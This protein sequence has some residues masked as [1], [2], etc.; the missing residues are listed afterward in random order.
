[1]KIY[2]PKDRHGNQ[3]GFITPESF[4]YDENGKSLTDK[5]Y[6]INVDINETKE[7]I[8]NTIINLDGSTAESISDVKSIADSKA[9]INDSAVDTNTTWSSRKINEEDEKIKSEISSLSNTLTTADNELSNSISNVKSIADSKTSIDDSVTETGTTWSSDKINTEITNVVSD[10]TKLSNELNDLTDEVTLKAVIDDAS[11]NTSNTWSGEKIN[12]T[13]NT[14]STKITSVE[15]LANSKVAI[16]DSTTGTDTTWS[17]N[18]INTRISDATSSLDSK[19]KVI[20]GIVNSNTSIDDD[21]SSSSTTWSSNKINDAI[22]ESVSNAEE[23]LSGEITNVS[24]TMNQKIDST[25]TE[26]KSYTDTKIS[27]L[28][29]SAPETLSTLK[30]L[31]DALSE[32]GEVVEA[33]NDAIAEKAD[34]KEF[35]EHVNNSMIHVTDAERVKWNEASTHATSNHAP[36]DAEKNQNA[37][38]AVKI[39]IETI[40]ADNTMDTLTL[41]EGSHIT[42]T[43]DEEND[44]ITIAHSY[45]NR[46]NPTTKVTPTYGDAFTAIDSV[47]TNDQGHVIAVNTKT[48]TL[49][50]AVATQT[51]AGL[52]SAADKKKLDN[53]EENAEVNQN[54]FSKVVVGSSTIEADTKT[55]TLTLAAGTSVTLTPNT[56]S[57]KVTITH[58][59]VGRENNTSKV[60]PSYSE[61]FTAIDSVTT[62]D[63]GHVTAV[64]TKTVTLPKS[65][66]RSISTGETN[67]T[68]KVDTDGTTA[69]VSVKGLTNAAYTSVDKEVKSGSTN[70]ITSGA[71]YTKVND[72]YTTLT[73]SFVDLSEDVMDL[74]AEVDDNYV[75]LNDAIKNTNSSVANLNTSKANATDLE[76]YVTKENPTFYSASVSG[77]TLKVKN[78]EGDTCW[79][80][81]NGNG[82]RVDEEG[83][84][85]YAEEFYE[86][87]EQLEDKYCLLEDFNEHTHSYAGSSSAGG[88]ATSA[89]KLDSSAGNSNTPVYFK[90]G[91]PTA[92]T[93]LVLSTSGNAATATKLA[94]ARNIKL[95][96]DATGSASFNGS[97]DASISATLA[98]SGVT[99]G[100]YGPSANASPAHSGTFSVPY[101][102]VDAKGRVTAASTKTIKLPSDNNTDTKVTNELATT[103]KAYVTGT[104]SAT[105][106]TGTQVFDTGVYLDT[107]AGQLT[108]TTF[109]GALS[110][111]ASTAS[112]LATARTISLTGS[113][114]GSGSFDGSG[115]LSIATTTN[116]THSY[117]PLSGG[118]LTISAFYGLNIKRSDTNGSAISYQNSSGALGGVGFLSNGTFAVSSGSNTDGGIFKATT[119]SATFP[120]TV[121]ATTFSGALSGNAST[122]TKLATARNI[123][124]TGDVTGSASFNGSADASISST[125]A[126]SGVTAGSYGPSANASP[127]HSGTFSVPYITVDAKGRVTAASTKTIKLPS[128]NNTDT[129]VT[130]TLAKTTKAYVTGTTSDTTN[131]GTQVFDTGVYLDTTAGQLTATT[132]KGALSGN[133]STASKL[134]TA[135]TISLTGSVTGSG[136]FDGS[137]NLSIATTTNHT[138]SYLP[139][140]G[141]TVTGTLVLSKTTDLSGTANNSPALIVG[142]TATTAH[143]EMDANEIQAKKNGTTTTE[144]Y[145]NQDGGL[146]TVGT[147]GLKVNGTI[148]ST[149]TVYGVNGSFTDVGISSAISLLDGSVPFCG[150]LS[151]SIDA[152]TQLADYK[153]CLGTFTTADGT[154]WNVISTRHRNGYGDGNKYGMYIRSCLTASGDLLWGKQMGASAS[155]QAERTILD[156]SNYTSYCAKASHTHSSLNSSYST[157]TDSVTLSTM[158]GSLYPSTDGKVDLGKKSNGT[159][160]FRNGYFNGTLYASGLMFTSVIDRG[161]SSG[162]PNYYGFTFEDGRLTPTCDNMCIGKT[163]ND[164]ST[165]LYTMYSKYIYT[166]NIYLQYKGTNSSRDAYISTALD[167]FAS[168]SYLTFSVGGKY[169]TGT[170]SR[171]D[172]KF[173][174]NN[175]TYLMTGSA[176]TGS[177]KTLGDSSNL[178]S[179]I[180][181]SSSTISTSD[182]NKK[183]DI[184]DINEKYENLFMSIAPKSYKFI[185]RNRTHIGAISQDIEE[186]LEE[187][188]LTANDFGG[189]CKDI[190]YE[191]DYDEE[192]NEIPESKREVKDEDGN[193]VYDYAL[194]YEEFIMLNTHMIQKLYKINEEKDNTINEL[195]EKVNDL[196]DRLNKLEALLTN[197]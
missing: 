63:Q 34:G 152:L 15:N 139:L 20:E 91:K 11:V 79:L 179:T 172:V 19:I 190:R 4:V 13:A 84:A 131:T 174:L 136:S 123:K 192:G 150:A 159:N 97:A 193:T 67:G 29:D 41:V 115:N 186:S 9:A 194:R 105:T 163:S 191:Y 195:T 22:E 94:T 50:N 182:R 107:T 37:F 112:K 180:Y 132:F 31:A 30:E 151:N 187:V 137:G 98:S 7:E 175:A 119:T 61:T 33:L 171:F 101:I 166:S 130:N 178:W 87:G 6:Q 23:E 138:H 80:Y 121:T 120:G 145:L 69:N 168:G 58:S 93:S 42:L 60:S 45:V 161:V 160:R 1:M 114:T 75:E 143:I 66:V 62:N 170:Y 189:F 83:Y 109:K 44:E 134:A 165:S 92:C 46:D 36:T 17:S 164:Y 10:V 124:L 40:A 129:K 68:I 5:I 147:G 25:L 102:T 27:E 142:G 12:S 127:T 117:L 32:S 86:A 55:D 153:T 162:N 103:K 196:E 39:G 90:D 3:I 133:A 24:N 96:G 47:T 38:S 110:G 99:A 181:S 49:P 141:G 154:W 106:N 173:S 8:N 111:N 135:R 149:T 88:S 59:D 26:S 56:D 64:N 71:V 122:A 126:S 89:V 57:D 104:T 118:T 35:S 81:I 155:W 54:A 76:N 188:G 78:D 185:D 125:L 176:F 144:L 18:K 184:E 177:G 158:Y 148:T 183:T 156:S 51:A 157:A 169:T 74:H 77:T 14:L 21:T 108:A 113:V 167:L 146:V 16:D 82:V 197:Q 53:I 128:D 73:A 116:H 43:P 100:S 28:V 65:G 48:I 72:V 2:Y 85:F 70:L 140:S 95:T 52:E